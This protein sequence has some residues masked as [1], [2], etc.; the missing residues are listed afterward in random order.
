ME[1]SDVSI[2]LIGVIA[3]GVLSLYFGKDDMA[4]A[5]IGG[6]LGFMAKDHITTRQV[7]Q[8]TEDLVLNDEYVSVGDDD[9][10]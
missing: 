6:L 7:A 1:F 8:P 5:I 4:M 2:V 9:A 3:I 10:E